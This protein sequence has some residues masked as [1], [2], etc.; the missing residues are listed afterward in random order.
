MSLAVVVSY[1]RVLNFLTQSTTA[2][3]VLLDCSMDSTLAEMAHVCVVM[4]RGGT[5]YS[6]N[7]HTLGDFP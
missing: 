6:T 4:R 2:I 3:I 7:F 1:A 5:F